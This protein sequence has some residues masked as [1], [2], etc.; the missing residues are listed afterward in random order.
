MFG[1]DDKEQLKDV[2]WRSLNENIAT[3]TD[4]VVIAKAVGSTEILATVGE[5]TATCKVTVKESDTLINSI[6]IRKL[7]KQLKV[8][9]TAQLEIIDEAGNVLQDANT[10][11]K[12]SNEEVATV[13][14]GLVKAVKKGKTII[15][16]SIGD[17]KASY[18]L[19]VIEEKKMDQSI[20]KNN[21]TEINKTPQIIQ[22]N[23]DKAINKN[24]KKEEKE[25]CNINE[26]KKQNNSIKSADNAD[27]NDTN[28]IS[29][30]IFMIIISLI[31]LYVSKLTK[32]SRNGI[33][34]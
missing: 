15:S 25:N 11:W 33:Y 4:G 23:N 26:N 13:S 16:V 32:K 34:K 28:N 5:S 2:K 8:G 20:S 22:K 7:I 6:S 9:E 17:M 31:I 14:G 3:V 12:S 29:T 27:T 21:E 18:E 1:T 10:I 30:N 24:V 19:N